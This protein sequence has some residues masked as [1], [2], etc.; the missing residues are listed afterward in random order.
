MIRRQRKTHL[1][2]WAV[3]ALALPLSLTVILGLAAGQ[4]SERAPVL[5]EP[6]PP[7]AGGGG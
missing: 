2:V 6:P 4:V 1:A 5:L 7:V 3:L